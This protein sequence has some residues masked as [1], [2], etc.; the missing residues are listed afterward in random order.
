MNDFWLREAVSNNASWCAAI[1][2]SHEI[3]SALLDSV[4]LSPYPMP[5]LYPNM[6]TVKNIVNVDQHIHQIDSSLQAGWAIKDSF[7]MLEL[8]D[9]SFMVAFDAFWYCLIPGELRI[10]EKIPTLRINYVSNQSDLNRWTNAWGEKEGIFKP[11]LLHDDAVE[12]LFVE[13]DE[14]IVA[15]LVANQSGE[16]VGISNVFGH[17]SG[18]LNCI[19]SISDKYPTK[20]IVGYGDSDEL[21][22]LS[23]MG[24][25]EV[26]ELRI[27]IRR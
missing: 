5:P 10:G 4:W 15:G 13:S 19:N 23:K 14:K 9:E 3:E 17:K 22:A 11:S 12:F 6:V 1:A 25:R 20:G 24:F 26:G 21:T 7:K 27:W 8:R 18:I 2:A 16:S